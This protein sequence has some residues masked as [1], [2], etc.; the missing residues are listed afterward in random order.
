M[1]C[2][3]MIGRYSSVQGQF[4]ARLPDGRVIVRV[5]DRL[6]TGRPVSR[7]PAELEGAA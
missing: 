6:Y 2:T 1:L 4:F 7:L 3:V 5:G